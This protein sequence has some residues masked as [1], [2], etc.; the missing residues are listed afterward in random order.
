MKTCIR[1]L[2]L[3]F[4][5]LFSNQQSA[6]S[7]IFNRPTPKKIVI[8]TSKGGYTHMAV[9]KALDTFFG[10]EYEIVIVNPFETVLASL[11]IVK[12]LTFNSYDAEEAYNSMLRSGWTRL[13]NFCLRNIGLPTA[14]R[15]ANK[16]EKLLTNYLA[17]LKPDMLISV[18]PVISLPASNA[19]KNLN[20]PF[21]LVTLDNDLTAWV[22]GLKKLTHQ[23][24]ATTIGFET[25]LTRPMLHDV[26]IPD[27]K[28]TAS[29]FPVRKDFLEQ[30]N[31]PAI[32]TDW[33]IPDNKF[34]ITLV[35]GGAG[36]NLMYR[37]AR[38]IAKLD[39][40]IHLMVLVGKN[41]Y[42]GARLK[43][44]R[45]S[46]KVTLRVVEFTDRVSDL[47]AASNLL[48]TKPGPSIITEAMYMNLP[49]LIDH[50]TVHPFW[51]NIN[52][53]LVTD[54]KLGDEIKNLN[55]LKR[56]IRHYI[57]DTEYYQTIK[58]NIAS[59]EKED[60]YKKIGHLIHT[61][62]PPRRLHLFDQKQ[63]FLRSVMAPKNP[64]TRNPHTN[65]FWNNYLCSSRNNLS[66]NRFL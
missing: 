63:T 54:N 60:F 45:C 51:E 30:K 12:T 4:V 40:D 26:G 25:P 36:S 58:N 50:T 16:V 57:D 1:F 46:E 43:K 17:Q 21:L 35:M 14:K 19:A 34:V 32:K 6:H 18:I 66:I 22:P 2:S 39:R 62:C 24:F 7:N 47:M 23:K 28:I 15:Q 9:A 8:L 10:Q 3:F 52:I 29:G 38:Q 49:M 55:D 27:T 41:E 13:L 53:K 48:I 65:R 59:F 5:M 44:I 56:I 11:D 20:I 33:Q 31:I 64:Y 42:L 61:M 37:Y